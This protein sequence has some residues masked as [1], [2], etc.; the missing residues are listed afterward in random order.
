M[1][2]KI[3]SRFGEIEYD[4][5]N[6]LL[7]PEGLVGFETLRNFVVMPNEKEGPLFWIQSV[8]DPQVAFILTDPTG[9]YFDYKV[10]PDGRERQKLGIDEDSDC[11]IVSVVSVPEDR[12]ITLNLAAPILF[13]PET[14][15]ALQ[16]ILE[17]TQFSPQTPLP[18]V[19]G[20]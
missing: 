12:K 15:R 2:E 10:V 8:D 6:T 16:V 18:T 13:A 5:D 11:L 1:M 14:N 19:E 3:Q 4:P 9:F 17:G 20:K 7:F